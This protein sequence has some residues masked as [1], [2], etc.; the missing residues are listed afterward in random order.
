[1]EML[2]V[3]G[4]CTI[5]SY[6]QNAQSLFLLQK[7]YFFSPLADTLLQCEFK[8]LPLAPVVSILSGNRMGEVPFVTRL[9]QSA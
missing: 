2:H 5:L 8:Y 7:M 3:V 4:L 6:T 9:E 1:M